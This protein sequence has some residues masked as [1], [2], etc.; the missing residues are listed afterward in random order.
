MDLF[1]GSKFVYVKLI[2]IEHGYGWYLKIAKQLS[3]F[4]FS[5]LSL[6]TS[7]YL[8]FSCVLT[9]FFLGGGDTLGFSFPIRLYVVLVS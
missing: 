2:L 4:F 1:F 5:F 3:Y 7:H 6:T 8:T 9:C